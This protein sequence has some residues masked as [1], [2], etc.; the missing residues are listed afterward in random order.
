MLIIIICSEIC[1]RE[2]IVFKYAIRNNSIQ[3]YVT[4][5]ITWGTSHCCESTAD[6]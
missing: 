3:S 4:E 6:N 2:Q 5:L 1:N